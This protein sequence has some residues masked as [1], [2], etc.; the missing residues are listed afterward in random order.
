MR[1]LCCIVSVVIVS[2]SVAWAG[3]SYAPVRIESL[4]ISGSSY[5]LVVAP[6]EL[7]KDDRYVGG[8]TLFTI[9]G[10]Y[11]WLNGAF[12][13]QPGILSEEQHLVALNYLKSAF[14]SGDVVSLGAMG[15]GFMPID[16]GNP[17]IVRSRALRLQGR[18][19]FSFHNA[20]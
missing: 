17:C 16:A 15:Q 3:G 14:K 19:V 5:T 8:C 7:A 11:R 1:I 6:T 10:T 2:G 4:E 20:V 12:L 13:N 9:R 18:V